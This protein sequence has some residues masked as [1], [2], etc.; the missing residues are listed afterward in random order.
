[1]SIQVKN[2]PTWSVW[3]SLPNI[4]VSS[5]SNRYS[6]DLPNIARNINRLAIPAVTLFVLSNLNGTL[7]G[8]IEYAVCVTACTIFGT[9]AAFPACATACLAAL[10]F[11][12]P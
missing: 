3:N 9:P 10:A 7:A 8:P 12:S 2:A 5:I 6:L 1:M 4:N 11:P